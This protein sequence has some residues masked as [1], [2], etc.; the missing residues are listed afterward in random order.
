VRATPSLERR[1]PGDA[2]AR[3]V[4]A[5]GVKASVFFVSFVVDPWIPVVTTRGR[6]PVTASGRQDRSARPATGIR[7]VS[8]DRNPARLL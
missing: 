1:R 7:P 5:L 3:P 2:G 6:A 8:G 4:E